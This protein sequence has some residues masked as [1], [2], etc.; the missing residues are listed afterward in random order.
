MRRAFEGLAARW[1]RLP[2][3]WSGWMGKG[4]PNG[5]KGRAIGH[6][7]HWLAGVVTLH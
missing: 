1:L 4:L 6:N 3:K 7:A 5:T 2:R